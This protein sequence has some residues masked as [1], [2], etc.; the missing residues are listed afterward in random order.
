MKFLKAL[1]LF[2]LIILTQC[3]WS[4]QGWQEQFNPNYIY[5]P[6][7]PATTNTTLTAQQSGNVIVFN[8]TSNNTKF[9]LPSAVPGL[10]FTVIGDSAKYF[11][12]VIQSGDIINFSTLATG[13]GISYSGSAAKGDSIELQCQTAGQW[14]MY[15][16]QGTWAKDNS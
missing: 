5:Y 11:H 14:S 3:G 13:D 12:I 4:S 1:P 10:D 8:G 9:T 16:R 7:A 6:G 2:L 15:G